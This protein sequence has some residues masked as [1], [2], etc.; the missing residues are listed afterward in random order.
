MILVFRIRHS[1]R[2]CLTRV[3]EIE[4]GVGAQNPSSVYLQR[5]VRAVELAFIH[6]VP[7]VREF[8]VCVEDRGGGGLGEKI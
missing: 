7:D 3:A 4:K 6:S 5:R 2:H 1:E 8:I